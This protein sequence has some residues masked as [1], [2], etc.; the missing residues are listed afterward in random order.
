[1]D[2]TGLQIVLR[3]DE[4]GVAPARAWLFSKVVLGFTVESGSHGTIG[5]TLNPGSRELRFLWD[6]GTS[7]G[8]GGMHE[9]E[10][11]EAARRV[12]LINDSWDQFLTN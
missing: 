2:V 5:P 1:M 8:I 11:L 4:R 10:A 9:E 6:T 12:G 7:N 3:R